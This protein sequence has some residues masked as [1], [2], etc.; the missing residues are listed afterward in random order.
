MAVAV[1][2]A[3]K[4]KPRPKR[5][6]KTASQS[7]SEQHFTRGVLVRGEAVQKGAALV[8]GATHE[9]IGVGAAG[10]AILRRKR[11]SVA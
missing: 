4:T 11:F 5:S 2:M 3:G 1:A 10:S 6:K 7:K 8:P 9:V